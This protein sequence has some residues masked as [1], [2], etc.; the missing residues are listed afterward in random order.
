MITRSIEYPSSDGKS[1]IKGEIYLPESSEKTPCGI[2]QIVHGVAEHIGR[3]RRFVEYLVGCGYVVCAENHLGHGKGLSAEE[4]GFFAEKDG[5]L[6][7]V[8]DTEKLSE[9]VKAEYPSLDFFLFGH[10]MGSFIARSVY[11]RSKVE[12]SGL[13]LSG[14][15]NM[16]KL[17]LKA[18]KALAR[19]EGAKK[20]SKRAESPF[21]EKLVFGGYDKRFSGE[22][23]SAWISSLPEEIKRYT[24]DP[25]CGFAI[26]IGM[27]YDLLDGI[28]FIVTKRYIRAA[29]KD[30]PILLISGDCDPVGDMGKG[31]TGAYKAFLS[32]GVKDV[33]MKLYEGARHEILNDYCSLEVME[34]VAEWASAKGSKKTV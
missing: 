6:R 12:L 22:N 15:G 24:D 32:A 7:V 5:W 13:V 23:K 33:E 31:V 21:L 30:V 29:E 27:Y 34:K 28:D 18:G 1:V 14:T 26:K 2:F 11:L 17:I 19:L 3:Y 10:S 8:E 16:P 4:R 20:K 9:L 25:D